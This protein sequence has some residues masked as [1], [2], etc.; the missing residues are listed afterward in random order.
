MSKLIKMELIKLLH[1]KSIL[2]IWLIMLL[3]CFLNN[4]LFYRDYDKEGNYLY[5]DTSNLSSEIDTI[6]KELKNITTTDNNQETIASL[7]TKRDILKLQ[8]EFKENSF[9][10]NKIND[11]MY[12]IIYER[13]LLKIR[14]DTTSLQEVENTYQELISKLKNNN[15]KYFWNKEKEELENTLK[16]NNLSL[17]EKTNLKKNLQILNYRIK[18]NIKEDNSYLNKALETYISTTNQ[19]KTLSKKDPNKKEILKENKISKITLKD[20]KNY[21]QE[22]TLNYQLR[23]IIEDYEFFLV[24]I[25][26]MT[27]SILV[28]EEFQKGTIKFILIKPYSRF[29]ILLSKYLT[30]LVILL[31]SILL[32]I[33]SELILGSIFFGID[34][35]KD[36]VLVFNYLTNE[37]NS[38]SIFTYMFIRILARIPFYLILILISL[39]IGVF[40]A[41]TIISIM[42]PLI[43]TTF[44]STIL[45]IAITHNIS[46]FKY[47][48]NLNWNFQ[49]YLFGANSS[50]K[51]INLKFSIIIYSIY[52]IVLTILTFNHFRHKD[53]KN[54]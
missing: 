19:L 51:E 50:F 41:N 49:D 37:I 6:E 9:Q 42:I 1:K 33:S 21:N 38:L 30:T 8:Q 43:L 39:S 47:F 22:N 29:I 20:K 25:T 45:D 27:I 5:N 16:D 3:F 11:Y 36:K 31:L 32:L 28:C 40:S 18:E 2:V 44:T 26:L 7:K 17:E 10:Y 46:I 12:D 23:T 52:F 35:L 14:N 48:I 24:L 13:N 54:I 34:S 15:Y 4:Y 53:I